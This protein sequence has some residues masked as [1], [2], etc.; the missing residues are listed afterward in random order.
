MC[1]I[2]SAEKILKFEKEKK[3]QA[4]LNVPIETFKQIQ[5]GLPSPK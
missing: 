2:D 4:G 3:K 1:R 5:V